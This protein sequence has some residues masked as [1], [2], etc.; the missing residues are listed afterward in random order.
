ML[1]YVIPINPHSISTLL[2]KHDT[3]HEST[4]C[5]SK[6]QLTPSDTPSYSFTLKI[7]TFNELRPPLPLDREA[8]SEHRTCY[9]T[10]LTRTNLFSIKKLLFLK[11]YPPY[12]IPTMYEPCLSK[13]ISLCFSVHNSSIDTSP[14]VV[15]IIVPGG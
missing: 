13:L 4:I 11:E 6:K 3:L 2:V 5:A 10:N 9:I 14:C 7:Y 8:M 15:K 12:F 1:F